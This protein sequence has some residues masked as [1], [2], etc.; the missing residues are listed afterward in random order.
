MQVLALGIE[1]RQGVALLD[2]RLITFALLFGDAVLG[3]VVIGLGH[4]EKDFL[5]VR[6]IGIFLQHVLERGDGRAVVLHAVE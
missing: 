6:G 5:A 3:I 1:I 2:A 4:V